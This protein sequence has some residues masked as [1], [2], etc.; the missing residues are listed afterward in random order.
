VLY[1]LLQKQKVG[2]VAGNNKHETHSTLKDSRETI[3][4]CVELA[5]LITLSLLK[6]Y[7][8]LYLLSIWFVVKFK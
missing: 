7:T 4:N 3:V 2:K 1:I 5:G 6:Y 8:S